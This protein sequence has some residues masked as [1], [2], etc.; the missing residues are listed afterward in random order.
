MNAL[1]GWWWIAGAIGGGVIGVALFSWAFADFL[2]AIEV[3]FARRFERWRQQRRV[4]PD[5]QSGSAL[6]A[7]GA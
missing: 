1:L 4:P 6:G 7:A 2:L 5:E 3:P